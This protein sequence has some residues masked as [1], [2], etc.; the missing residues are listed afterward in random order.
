MTKAQPLLLNVRQIDRWN[1][2]AQNAPPTHLEAQNETCLT[3]S[4]E[5]PGMVPG[6][7]L[8]PPHL[9]LSSSSSSTVPPSLPSD[10]LEA[11]L[12]DQVDD[13]DVLERV[14][15]IRK[16]KKDLSL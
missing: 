11:G 8:S 1:I 13:G 2:C 14:L 6:E 15:Q 10:L 9:V 3:N 16:S 4:S 7:V 5:D 12:H